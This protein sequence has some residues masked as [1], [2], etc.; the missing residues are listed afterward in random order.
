MANWTEIQ[1]SIWEAEAPVK[2]L[3]YLDV[4][5]KPERIFDDQQHVMDLKVSF[6][7]GP[8]YRFGKLSVSGLSPD[9][10]AKARK[11]WAMMPGDPFDYEYPKQFLPV[12]FREMGA[13]R[14]KYSL[15]MQNGAGDHV[16]D[17][18]LMFE[19]K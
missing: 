19:P 11:I 6:D 10:E 7:R 16:M 3:G 15:K 13:A 9:L 14:L 1:N 5:A 12:F 8:L 2:R 18:A 4:S 17:F